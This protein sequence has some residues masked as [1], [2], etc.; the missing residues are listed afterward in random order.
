MTFITTMEMML[1]ME[2]AAILLEAVLVA[3]WTVFERFFICLT[4]A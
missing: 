4:L 3:F 1:K 2:K